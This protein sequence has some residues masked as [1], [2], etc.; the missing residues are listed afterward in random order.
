M[1]KPQLC[2]VAD[3]A[4]K[5]RRSIEANRFYPLAHFA[6]AA[7]SGLLGIQWRDLRST[8]LYHPSLARRQIRRSKPKSAVAIYMLFDHS[9]A[10]ISIASGD[11]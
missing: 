5:P 6:L 10:C 11:C 1:A 3:A 8:Q 2:A 7:A 9:S 4:G